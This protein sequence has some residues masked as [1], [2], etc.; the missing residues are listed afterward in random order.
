MFL[1]KFCQNLPTWHEETEDM[2]CHCPLGTNTKHCHC[3]LGTNTNGHSA[4]VLLGIPGAW[5]QSYSTWKP[6]LWKEHFVE[7]FHWLLRIQI[8]HLFWRWNDSSV[9]GSDTAQQRHLH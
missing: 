5:N 2:H 9:E 3:P 8:W 7:L 4:Q 1:P 6:G